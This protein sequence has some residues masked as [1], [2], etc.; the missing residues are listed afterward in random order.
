MMAATLVTTIWAGVL[1]SSTT[2]WCAA[3]ACVAIVACVLSLRVL[4]RSGRVLRPAGVVSNESGTASI[5]FVLVTPLLMFMVLALLQTM[6]VMTGQVYVHHAAFAA[7]RSA[8]VQIPIDDS[9]AGVEAANEIVMHPSSVKYDAIRRAAVFAL[10]AV[11]GRSEAGLT[12]GEAFEAGLAGMYDAY[13][14]EVPNWVTALAADRLRYAD[15][16]THVTLVDTFI[17]DGQV[18]FVDMQRNVLYAYGPKDPVTVSV[19]HWFNLSMP[20]ARLIFADGDTNDGSQARLEAQYTLT[21][22]GVSDRL[23]LPPPWPREP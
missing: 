7:T 17:A 6:L 5:E 21:N 14:R 8:I 23:P 11:S 20:Y 18:Q 9:Q 13:G 10:V 16:N 12:G 4:V 15:A 3:V 1:A 2:W 19:R 22:E